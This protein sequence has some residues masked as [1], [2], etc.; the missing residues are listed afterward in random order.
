MKTSLI[1]KEVIFYSDN[2]IQITSQIYLEYLSLCKD[3]FLSP[4]TIGKLND[5]EKM[6]K[7]LKRNNKKDKPRSL[8]DLL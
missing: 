1:S 8:Y 5:I 2:E 7:L 3:N 4:L 6:I